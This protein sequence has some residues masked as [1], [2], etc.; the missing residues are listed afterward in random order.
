MFSKKCFFGCVVCFV[1]RKVVHFKNHKTDN[2][3][4][5]SVWKICQLREEESSFAGICT[6]LKYLP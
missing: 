3:D 2:A 1:S 5:K 6:P 4:G